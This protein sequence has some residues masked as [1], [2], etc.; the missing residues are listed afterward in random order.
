MS[1]L[2]QI[3]NIL[4]QLKKDWGIAMD[5]RN[6]TSVVDR[7]TGMTQKSYVSLSVR[8][9][10]LLPVKLTPSF[11]YDLS[12]IAANKNFTY[13]GLFGAGSRV[14]IVDGSDV[15][16]TFTVKED[17]QLIIAKAVYSVK[18]VETLVNKLGYLLTVT[19]LS[20]LENV[21]EF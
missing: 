6:Q 19:T 16:S 7:K 17:T 10:I 3:K 5:L 21:D 13:G 8:R 9:G 18:N 1:N 14:V 15:P 11:V 12:F 20:N 2:R 4:Y